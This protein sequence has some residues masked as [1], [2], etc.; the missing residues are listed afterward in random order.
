MFG[1]VDFGNFIFWGESESIEEHV[2]SYDGSATK[3]QNMGVDLFV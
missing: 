2:V 1:M 3:G